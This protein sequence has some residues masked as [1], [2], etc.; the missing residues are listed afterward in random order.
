MRAL[1]IDPSSGGIR[2]K[3]LTAALADLSGLTEPLYSLAEVLSTVPGCEKCSLSVSKTKNGINGTFLSFQTDESPPKPGTDIHEKL[4]QVLERLRLLPQSEKIARGVLNDLCYARDHLLPHGE[5][6]PAFP[7]SE[8]IFA[9]LGPLVLLDAL[10]FSGC[11][12]TSSPPALGWGDQTPETSMV[13]EILKKHRIPVA[14]STVRGALT[15]PVG[16]ALL[17][18]IADV[19]ES[20]PAMTPVATGYGTD[21]DNGIERAPLMV[22]EG[23]VSDRVCDRIVILETNLDDVSGEIIGYTIERLFSEGAVD[24]FVIPAIGKKNRPVDIL[25]VITDHT[26]Y[27]HLL[28]VLM[29]ETGTLGVRILDVPR[30][31]AERSRGTVRV[32]VAGCGFDVN[33]KT[34]SVS[35]KIIS[36]KPEY[37]D[38]RRIARILAIPLREVNDEIRKQLPREEFKRVYPPCDK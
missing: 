36:R 38:L 33:V 5:P 7:V 35:G 24:V 27:H 3:I 30:L 18:H 2:G 32:T 11:P 25:S 14:E 12:V 31:V 9:T 20:F 10:H 6:V 1:F 16:A 37:E 19:W 23:E 17:A 15:S 29:E 34:S 21:A 22:V 26:M 4:G 28:S 8:T 13:L